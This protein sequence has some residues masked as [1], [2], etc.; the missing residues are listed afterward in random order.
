[1]PVLFFLAAADKEKN[2]FIPSKS[3]RRRRLRA[4]S[5]SP[6]QDLVVRRNRLL[7]Q[8]HQ[9]TVQADGRR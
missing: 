1:M 4:G 5:E 3:V 9:E 2:G 8:L 6:R 7:V